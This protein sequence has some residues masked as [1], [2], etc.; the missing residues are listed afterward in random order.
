MIQQVLV[1]GWPTPLKNMSSSVDDIPNWM[2]II[3][4][5]F[6]A[7]NQWLLTIINHY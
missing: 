1:G 4:Q 5:M 6:Q 3:I 2:E 7:T